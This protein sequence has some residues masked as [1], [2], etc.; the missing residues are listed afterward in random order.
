MANTPQAAKRARQAE[1]RRLHNAGLRSRMRTYVKNVLKAI[2]S[3]D[4]AAA[5][6][7]YRAAVPV[8]DKTADKEMFHKNKAARYKSRLNA[9]IRAMS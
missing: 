2:A 3:G 4:K 1:R 6:A 5:Q 8:I 7:A 9:R